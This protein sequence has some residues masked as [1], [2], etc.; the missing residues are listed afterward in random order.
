[1][2]RLIG[3]G[4][5]SLILALY[6][7]SIDIRE[8]LIGLF[9]TLVFAGDLITSFVIVLITDQIGRRLVLI[10]SSLLMFFTGL[11][12]CFFENYYILTAVAVLGIFTPS[13]VEVGPF[14]TIEQSSI[15]SLAPHRDR[16]DIY[17]WYTFLGMFCAA[18][19]SFVA[20]ILV[21]IVHKKWNHSLV[22]GYRSVFYMYTFLAGIHVILS[23]L[24]SSAIEPNKEPEV[25]EEQ[26][27]DANNN[28]TADDGEESSTDAIDETTPLVDSIQAKKASKKTKF[29]LSGALF[30]KLNPHTYSIVFKLALLFGLDAFASSLTPHSWISYYIKH[31]FDVPASYLGSVFFTTGIVSGFTSLCST[32]LTKRLGA[33]VT[34]V[35]THLPA[36]L[37]LTIVPLPSSFVMTMIILV[38]RASTQSMDVAPKHVFLATL[39]A[40][41]ERTAVFGFV[42]VV[43]TL[44]Q[45]VGPSI[46]GILT[47][48]G[49]QWLT[50]VIAGTLKSTYDL[51]IL[52]TF[53]TYNRHNEH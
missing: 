39:V 53:L 50:F 41:S 37:L 8:E 24:I 26:Q 44:A 3:F 40:D 18:F 23:L 6:L 31:K 21:D 14:R 36:S 9:M 27:Q 7:K 12:F 52:A 25:I 48:N 35:V 10:F 1:M 2:I 5:T 32:S 28:T 22:T 19:G 47:R 42:N 45:T 13:G 34:M 15:A 20:G 30:P 11:T 16:S 49:M 46:V 43:K 17:A 29:S 4:A 38:T 51:G 33:V